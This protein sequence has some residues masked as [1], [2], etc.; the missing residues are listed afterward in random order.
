MLTLIK[1]CCMCTAIELREEVENTAAR[2]RY[3]G[4][5]HQTVKD[6]IALTKRATEKTTSDVS[7]AERLKLQQASYV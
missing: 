1:P 6:D 2:L 5:A 4:E 3:I 7:T